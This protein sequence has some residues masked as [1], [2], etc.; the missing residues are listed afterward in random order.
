MVRESAGWASGG[1]RRKLQARSESD[2]PGNL[3]SPA[4]PTTKQGCGR[5]VCGDVYG[6]WSCIVATSVS[7]LQRGQE[8]A[9]IHCGQSERKAGCRARTSQNLRVLPALLNLSLHLTMSAFQGNGCCFT[10]AFQISH[11]AP[12][13]PGL[14]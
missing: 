13:W 5:T 6:K 3:R 7:P 8:W 4:H 12:F 11:R 14:T 2:Q 9:Q 10:S 1:P